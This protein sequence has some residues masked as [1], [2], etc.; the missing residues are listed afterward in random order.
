V[1]DLSRLSPEQRRAVLAGDGPLL[2]VAGPGSGKTTVL[3]ARIAYL[4]A[5]RRIPPSSIL[6]VTFATKATQELKARL[7]GMLGDA[8]G[9][10]DVSTFHAF[11]LRILRQ[12][13]EELGLGPGPLAVYGREDALRVLEEA[14]GAVG[15]DLARRPLGDL[16]RHLEALRLGERASSPA[17]DEFRAL[18]ESYEA[19]LRRR[20]AVDY[21][22]MLALPLRLFSERP[23]ALRLYQDSYRV[24]LSDEFQDVSAA[25]YSLLRGLAQRHRNLMVVGDPRQT[26]YGWRGADA[27]FLLEFQRDFPEAELLRLD[28]NFR[29]TGRIVD[30]ANALGKALGYSRPLWTDNP[31]GEL[32]LL[33]TAEDETAEA[34]FVAAEIER[35]LAT[36]LIEHPG[37]AAVL[38]RTNGQAEALA[39]ALRAHGLPYRVLGRGDFFG[40][41]EVRDLVAYLRLAV[42]PDD[43]AALAR[44]VNI[45][46]RGLARL[47][48][49]VE[50]GPVPV[51]DLPSVATA[52]GPAAARG[53]SS[54]VE[55]IEALHRKRDESSP[56][57]LLDRVLERTRYV[58][59]LA[60]QADG[61]ARFAHVERFHALAEQS[62]GDL[63]SWLADLQ[64]GDD[65]PT[66]DDARK[67]HLST[68]HGAKGG[69]WRVVFV[70]GVEEG[71][72]P[73]A[74]A[75][76]LR[77]SETPAI[78]EELRV[79]YV[80][81]TRP[82]ER[83]YLTCCRTRH[84]GER[85]EGRHPSRFLRGLPAC[86]LQRAA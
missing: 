49:R 83:L 84:M 64:L 52:Y 41:R 6:A 56:A 3:A 7:A 22:S 55:L 12:W 1:L 11:G 36:G 8:A 27:R 20:G 54:L 81:V 37:Q 16:A 26:L 51:R 47:A 65:A 21:P 63:E 5:S 2:I 76:I 18:M 79:A 43:A 17:G 50:A 23:E 15:L 25:Q 62:D 70:V 30:L 10:V 14:A 61:Q 33:H 29:S 4:V 85:S 35:L 31:R 45:P 58:D 24:V 67:V 40:R 53:A 57:E 46:P 13:S 69:E 9:S 34:G 60:S 66:P 42:S 74:R 28:Q 38:Y 19:L 80:A 39:L 71:L 86:L 73:H 78:E 75:L 48:K 77:E 44:I 59:W 68:I 82:R 72:L 32:A